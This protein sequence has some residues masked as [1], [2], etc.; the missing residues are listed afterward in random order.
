M[1]AINDADRE[2]ARFPAQAGESRGLAVESGVSSPQRRGWSSEAW[3]GLAAM[4]VALPSAIAFGVTI[5]APL[6][7]T[8]AAQGAV[9]GIIGAIVLGIL[10]PLLGGT[11][12][13]VSGP[14]APAA[15]VLAALAAE[16][17]ADGA[18][19]AETLVTLGL[20]AFLAGLLQ[21]AFGLVRLGRL[22][23]Y[24][25]YPVVS[26]YL[27][28]VGL[29]MVTS[30]LPKLLGVDGGLLLD[31]LSDP[32]AWNQRG[33]AVGV[34]T[35]VAMLAAPRLTRV[36]PGVIL[37]LAAGV[38]TYLALAL[39]D[40]SL[41]EL[42]GNPLVVGP[43]GAGAKA[44]VPGAQA[45]AALRSALVALGPEELRQVAAPALTLAVLLSIDTLKTC[46]VLD[47]LTRSR[48]RSDRELVGQGVANIASTVLGGVPGAGQMGATLVNMTSGGT[49]RASGVIEGV[50]ALVAFVALGSLV[51]WVPNASLAA[52]LIVIGVRMVDWNSLT[53][54]RSRA[55]LLDFAVI[56]AVVV[57]AK[58]VS[59][60]AASGVG[61]A[62][63]IMLFVREQIGGAVVRRKLDGAQIS[64]KQ[65]RGREQRDVLVEQGERTVVLELQGSLFFGTADQLYRAL[66]PEIARRH[67]VIL[68]L[69]RVQSVDVTAIHVLG[70]V[71]GA[72]RDHGGH[73]LLCDLPRSLPSGRD[74]VRYFRE[75]GLVTAEPRARAFD[76][77]DQALE[78][79]ENQILGEAGL[80]PVAN[81]PPLELADMELLEGRKPETVAALLACIEARTVPPGSR[82]FSCGDGGD[83]LFMIRRGA[84]RIM[85]PVSPEAS[86][87]LATFGRGAYFGEMAFL[88]HEARSADAI[89]LVET[90]LYVLSRQR[91]D[92]FAA[93][94]KRAA[95]ALLLG[96]ARSLAVRLRQANGE[97]RS[98]REA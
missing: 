38:V 17:I 72:L 88:D 77:L 78:W 40:R 65:I 31:A 94:H 48:H 16:R 13:L 73:L 42:A 19:A 83:E 35:M 90:D 84:V 67:Y 95:M 82:V 29:V 60:I 5:L 27:S 1:T 30:Q 2:R 68:D 75:V 61:V 18:S 54:L 97:V 86:H 80:G 14:C 26:G 34:A 51:A 59:L 57:V 64:S 33:I 10:A 49:T 43:V 6:G 79:V 12:R 4:L 70:Q 74:M 41:L 44:D 92:A 36:V 23:K 3:G 89:A 87:H 98:L 9:A 71:E 21:V 52:I 66:E 46:V 91:F 63:A 96:I 24:M 47:A 81:E 20:V 11:A 62:L 56:V 39:A 85:L 45:V 32:V 53:M 7:G 37:A 50:L 22:I 8:Y 93:G 28:G 69:R 76:E 25:P 58:A 15:A 55:T